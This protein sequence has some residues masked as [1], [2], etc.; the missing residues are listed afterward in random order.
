MMND[1][2][3]LR[4]PQVSQAPQPS[5]HILERAGCSIHYWLT[6]PAKGPLIVFTHGAAM[7]NQ[8]FTAQIEALVGRYRLLWW[9]VPGHGRSRPLA[10]RYSVPYAT[11]ALLAMLDQVGAA[12]AILVGHSM[13]GYIS[14]EFLFRYPDRV[15]AL[16][17]I[18]SSC[19]T[20][21][22]PKWLLGAMRLSPHLIPILPYRTLVWWAARYISVTETVRDYIEMVVLR[23]TKSQFIEIWSAVMNCLHHEPGYQISQPVLITH[24]SEDSLGFGL[25]PRQGRAWVRRDPNSDYVVIPQAAHNA[26]QENPSFFNRALLDFLTQQ[27]LYSQGNEDVKYVQDRQ[28]GQ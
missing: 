3:F 14:Q 11:E 1:D 8:M 18:G 9:D 28:P 12:Q 5:E 27:E 15:A 26:Q 16:V 23:H 17:T 13:G 10:D 25:L 24:G 21:A 22:H 7:D 20:L 19:L 2:E 4:R 6:G